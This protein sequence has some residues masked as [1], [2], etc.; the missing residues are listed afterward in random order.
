MVAKYCWNVEDAPKDALGDVEEGLRYIDSL[1]TAPSVQ[2]FEIAVQAGL[3]LSSMDAQ[4]H[5]S[6]DLLIEKKVDCRC[7]SSHNSRRGIHPVHSN[8]PVLNFAQ[9]LFSPLR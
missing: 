7:C 2:K 4:L 6:W 9:K 3:V 8:H 1:K 5:K